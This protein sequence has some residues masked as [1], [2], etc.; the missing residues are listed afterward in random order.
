[1]VAASSP[2]QVRRAGIRD[3]YTENDRSVVM[4]DERVLVLSPI[5]TSILGAVRA[6]ETVGISEIVAAVVETHGAPERPSDAEAVV[7]R[8]ILDMTAHG[9]LVPIDEDSPTGPAPASPDALA[10][11]ALAAVTGALDS[12]LSCGGGD[13]WTLPDDVSQS[14]LLEAVQRQRVVSQLALHLDTSSLPDSL[15]ARLSA[16]H[17]ELAGANVDVTRDLQLL[18]ERLGDAGVRGLVFKG[19]ALAAQAWG[20][21]S[22]RGYGDIDLLVAPDD[23]AQAYT[24]LIGSGWS[25]EYTYPI[26]GPS[27]GWRHFIRTEYEMA[28]ARGRTSVDLH[29]H[30]V[31]ARAAFPDFDALWERRAEVS[32]A[33]RPVPTFGPYDALAHSASH[34]A[35]DHWR[36]LRGLADVH[37]LAA[38][39]ATWLTADRPLAGD[40]LLTL[41]IA[42][43][44]F[45]VPDAAP[46]VVREA[47]SA[48]ES[49]MAH[50][51]RG[52]LAPERAAP[53]D[54][55]PGLGTL[56]MLR[57][58]W[59]AKARPREFA[60]RLSTSAL[61]PWA[62]A[63][64]DSPHAAVAAPRALLLRTSEVRRRVRDRRQD[65]A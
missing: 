44:L 19:Q 36:W 41:G 8:Q 17:A 59:H 55:T 37:R 4:V 29:W 14:A 12:V 43:R 24:T 34:S 9:L 20:D 30:P 47:A 40:Q 48:A 5:A 56:Q 28:L 63:A 26:P 25:T 58:L 3:V 49:V 51:R 11:G 23:L 32:I 27:W 46:D 60:R 62:L 53:Q 16:L 15:T 10:S 50:V 22:A 2:A 52:Q 61:P 6:H 1:M 18:L 21:A 31:P 39:R 65:P 45:G 57:P 64:H 54:W 13:P 35:K 38:D 7:R 42:A 33:G